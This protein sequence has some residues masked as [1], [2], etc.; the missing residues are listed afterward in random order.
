MSVGKTGVSYTGSSSPS[1]YV[2]PKE[3]QGQGQVEE[4]PG[5][6]ALATVLQLYP[7]FILRSHHKNNGEGS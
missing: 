5:I 1:S 7:R 2:T 6:K 4:H 3:R